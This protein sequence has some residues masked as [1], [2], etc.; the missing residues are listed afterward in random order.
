MPTMPVEFARGR[1]AV[2]DRK[3]LKRYTDRRSDTSGLFFLARHF[4]VLF[5]TGALVVLSIGTWWILPAMVLHGIVMAFLFAPVHECSHATAFRTRWL[6][7]G[8]YWLLCLIY[9]VPPRMFRLLHLGHHR[10]TQIRGSDPEMVLPRNSTVRDYLHYV[11]A[12]PFWIRGAQWFLA[13]PFGKVSDKHRRFVPESAIPKVEREG[14]IVWGVYG[15]I[16]AAAVAAGSWMPLWLWILPRFLG[17][18][19]MRWLRIAEHAECEES[20]DLTVNT[21]TTRAPG[22]LHALFWNMS[23]HAEHHLCPAVPFHVLPELHEKIAGALFPV[24][25]G[26]VAVHAEVLRNLRTR[27][28][29]TWA[30]PQAA[31]AG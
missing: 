3:T 30:E 7:E 17:E 19:F 31:E 1:E 10:Y 5:A 20:A 4:L 15:S 24:G 26:Y 16:A 11:S 23:Y 8:V 25:S 27:T 18:P 29:V 28:G 22:W 6:N 12:I 9:L 2:I 21:R 13:V 14:W